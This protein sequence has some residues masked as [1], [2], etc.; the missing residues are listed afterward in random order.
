MRCRKARRAM[1]ERGLGVL[2][3]AVEADLESHL[4][5]CGTCAADQ[6]FHEQLV[7]ELAAHPRTAPVEVEVTGRVL[8]EIARLPASREVVPA[9]QL[10]LATLAAGSGAAL[11]L[12][13]GM[14]GTR[15]LLAGSWGDARTLAAAAGTVITGLGR[16][17]LGLFSLIQGI[18]GVV[19]DM[20]SVLSLVLA[21]LQPVFQVSIAASVLAMTMVTVVVIGRD[22][23]LIP[24]PL[25]RKE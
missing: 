23:G 1:V 5:S 14:L 13:M 19:L 6:K 15:E 25:A 11:A 21:K 22:L 4:A 12:L 2:S 8:R 18:G 20:A 24:L 3:G 16:P 17:L 7:K 10:G 9:R